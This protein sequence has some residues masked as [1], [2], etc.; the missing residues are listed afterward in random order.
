M[1]REPTGIAASDA[2]EEAGSAEGL[3]LSDDRSPSIFFPLD[4]IE[5][6][7]ALVEGRDPDASTVLPDLPKSLHIRHLELPLVLLSGMALPTIYFTIFADAPSLAAFFEVGLVLSCAILVSWVILSKLRQFANAKQLS[8][9]VPVYTFVF[10]GMFSTILFLDANYSVAFLAIGGLGALSSNFICAVY[11]RRVLKPHLIVRSGRAGEIRLGG[12]YLSAPSD[13]K[14]AEILATGTRN[15][16]LVADLHYPHSAERERLFAQTALAGVPVYHFR[17]ILEMQTGQVRV[18]HLSENEIGSLI[19]DVG[20]MFFKRCI[21][22]FACLM[23]LPILLPFFVVVGIM[24][25]LDSPGSCFFMQERIGRGG[26][27]FRVIKFRTMRER[28]V[29]EDANSAREDAMTKAEDDRITAVGHFLRRTRI[30]ELP[31][32]FNVLMGE[33]TLIGPRPEARTLADWYEAELPFYSYRHIV[34]P[35]ITGWAQ[36]NQGHVTDLGD[37]LAKLRYDFYYIKHISFWLDA[38]IVLKTIRVILT[39]KGAK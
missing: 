39:G 38:L 3:P 36:V 24:I 35:G 31:Q 10:F 29:S 1:D 6:T 14:L 9:V 17:Q 5:S 18:D 30:D 20:Y 22:L 15:W 13:K 25:K 33:M 21:D 28:D 23:L 4:R 16:A 12:Q 19:P 26:M 8:Y 11:R 7:E 27:P 2:V 34:R 37:I 32:I